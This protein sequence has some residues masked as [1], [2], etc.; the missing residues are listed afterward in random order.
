MAVQQFE[1][2]PNQ[3]FQFDNQEYEIRFYIDKNNDIWAVAQDIATVLGIRNIRENVRKLPPN[4]SSVSKTDG[5]VNFTLIKE[6]AIYRLI[7]RSNKQNA[8][9]FQRWVC[10]DILPSIRKNGSYSL[11]S[12]MQ[13]QLENERKKLDNEATKLQLAT[14]QFYKSVMD[15]SDTPQNK[16]Y[17]EQYMLNVMNNSNTY[18]RAIE[19]TDPN[20]YM[21]EGVTQLAVEHNI[22]TAYIAQKYGSP[23]GRYV[24]K[25]YK[26]KYPNDPIKKGKK[27]WASNNTHISPNTYKHKYKN[28]ILGWIREY[29]DKL[30]SNAQNDKPLAKQKKSIRSRSTTVRKK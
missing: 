18:T 5:L 10:E 8:L 2:T 14:F 27:I 30:D 9:S 22:T 1:P 11:H 17:F 23:C 20:T 12:N 24:A 4:W 15:N 26:Q 29:F 21:N 28:E 13:I 7:M 19:Y 3:L 6:P 25:Q 16:R